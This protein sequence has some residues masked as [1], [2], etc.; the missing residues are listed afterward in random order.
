MGRGTT[1]TTTTTSTATTTSTSPILGNT[2]FFGPPHPKVGK[3]R[4]DVDDPGFEKYL[5]QWLLT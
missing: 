4:T 1:T 2:T 5:D 3:N